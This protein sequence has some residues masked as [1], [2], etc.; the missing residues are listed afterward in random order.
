[1]LTSRVRRTRVDATFLHRAM[2]GGIGAGSARRIV[3][4]RTRIRRPISREKARLADH[5]LRPR[6]VLAVRGGP[7]DR[8]DDLHPTHDSTEH[9]MLP[10]QPMVVGEI[11]EELASA[12]VWAR[13]RHGDR[14]SCVS[15]V[16]RELVPDRV[17][18]ATEPGALRVTA[19]D[20]EARDHAVE[21]RTV[22]ESL[23]YELEEVPRGD[24]HSVVQELAPHIAP[25]RLGG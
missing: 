14:T 20:H 21:A 19:L 13:V 3:V 11:D 4:S 6:P 18:G 7:A 17:P 12:G 25:R 15:V 5:D 10:V 2:P 8:V 23:L 16:C 9:G 1:M 22:V 24:G